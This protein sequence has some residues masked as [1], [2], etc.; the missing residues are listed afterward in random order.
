VETVLFTLQI[1][2][3]SFLSLGIGLFTLPVV[4]GWVRP[5]QPPERWWS[6]PETH[7]PAP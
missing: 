4:T 1:T 5:R 7:P 6:K 2:S 3:I